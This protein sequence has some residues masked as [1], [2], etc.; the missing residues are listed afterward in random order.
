MQLAWRPGWPLPLLIQI[1]LPI[2]LTADMEAGELPESLI[3][4]VAA[5]APSSSGGPADDALPALV[6]EF[7][8]ENVH[9]Q[10]RS[11]DKRWAVGYFRLLSG[12][13][14][15]QLLRDVQFRSDDKR[16]VV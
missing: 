9:L 2:P 16:W 7:K 5:R 14:Y 13:G 3:A 11:D 6:A 4:S 12:F 1:P 10:Y 8:P 15:F